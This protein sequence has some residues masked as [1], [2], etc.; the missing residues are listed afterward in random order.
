[1]T[2][3][4]YSAVY[5]ILGSTLV[6]PLLVILRLNSE[7]RWWQPYFF[8]VKVPINLSSNGLNHGWALPG[9]IDSLRFVKWWFLN[10]TPSMLLAGI[11]YREGKNFPSSVRAIHHYSCYKILLIFRIWCQCLICYQR[12]K[13]LVLLFFFIFENF[14]N[15]LYIISSITWINSYKIHKYGDDISITTTKNHLYSY[16]IFLGS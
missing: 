5:F 8:F 13:D 9:A 1:M 16:L 10:F 14:T 2:R 12:D 6:V 11:I 4:F 7:L 15:F 3:I